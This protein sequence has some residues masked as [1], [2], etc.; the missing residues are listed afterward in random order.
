MQR[1]GLPQ[2]QV[3][4]PTAPPGGSGFEPP[5]FAHTEALASAAKLPDDKPPVRFRTVAAWASW[6]WSG[7]AF[8]AVI[9][10]FVF[11]VWLTSAAFIGN[12]SLVAQR[13]ADLD[14]GLTSSPAIDQVTSI[15]ADHSAWL[16][17]G[18]SI[19]GILVALL[20]P[21]MGRQSD[22]GGRHRRMLAVWTTLVIASMALMWFVQPNEPSL[23]LG[24]SLVALGNVFFELG[25]VNYNSLLSSVSTSSTVGRVSGIGWASGYLGG[26]VL[27]VIVLVGFIFP[28][29]GWFGV[30]DADGMRYRAVAVLCALWMLVFAI[31]TLMFVP[32]PPANSQVEPVGFVQSY[33]RLWHDIV[34]LWRTDRN[35]LQFLIASAIFRDGL[36]G[37]FTFGGV[38][39]A[40]TFGFSSTTVIVF[41]IVAN[42]VAGIATLGFGFLED[43]KGAKPIIVWSLVGM[44]VFAAIVFIGGVT[45][46][47]PWLFWVFGLL[48]CI[49]VGPAQ[50][51]SRTFLARLTPHGREGEFFGLYATTGRAVSFLAP[52][53]FS[54][55][56]II[57]GSQIFGIIGIALVLLAGL[58]LLLPVRPHPAASTS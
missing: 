20:A 7:S 37:V 46:A 12:S 45:G 1:A 42:V 26:I 30:G 14:A 4:I 43:R 35:I 58:L 56:I 2:R 9:T 54:V 41:A 53:A 47:G 40:V 27:L 19:A 22:A 8:N 55:F 48:L 44:V 31:P 38:I 28:D 52:L 51:A 11:T 23:W 10:T 21:V 25:S 36:A 3:R 15:L 6:D 13:D 18:L 5:I 57:G 32:E 29:V 50:S 49:F 17:W 39:A 16:G 24:I 33:V 34:E